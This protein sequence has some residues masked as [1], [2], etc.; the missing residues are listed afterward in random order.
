MWKVNHKDFICRAVLFE[1]SGAEGLVYRCRFHP[2]VAQRGL[3]RVLLGSGVSAISN[4]QQKSQSA[5]M[6]DW[7]MGNPV[8]STGDLSG[9]YLDPI[10]TTLSAE[11]YD[12]L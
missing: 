2:Y 10:N 3:F 4:V 8:L 1:I 7:A 9:N 11:W 12:G 5:P 6:S